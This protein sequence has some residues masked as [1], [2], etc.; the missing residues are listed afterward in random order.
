MYILYLEDH[1]RTCKWLITI[2]VIVSPQFLALWDPFQMAELHGFYSWEFAN[3]TYWDESPSFPGNSRGGTRTFPET[4][5]EISTLR[6]SKGWFYGKYVREADMGMWKTHFWGCR[7]GTLRLLS[8]TCS[9]WKSLCWIS[10]D[11][12][13]KLF[14]DAVFWQCRLTFDSMSLA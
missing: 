7:I 9:P 14:S 3:Y 8:G 2:M 11:A 4:L 10:L 12:D 1:P 13:L 5:T 6:I